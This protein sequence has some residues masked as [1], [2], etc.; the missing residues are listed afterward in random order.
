M[1]DTEYPEGTA[2]FHD[3]RPG[4]VAVSLDEALAKA[5]EEKARRE[6]LACRQAA[7]LRAL[8]DM[9]EQN[10]D[11]TEFASL[12]SLHAFHVRSAA[13]MGAI[14]RAAARSG[15][16]V[17]KKITDELHNVLLSWGP[18]GALVLA[19]RSEVCERLVL[20]SRKVKK[21]V[22]DPAALAAVPD[23]EVTETVEDVKWVCRPLLDDSSRAVS[24]LDESGAVA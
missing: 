10:P 7:G 6:E 19:W 11:L 24:S 20:G 14:V 17:E 18:V 1:S 3:A 23:V 16:K 12:A 9:I 4:E 21:T 8:A 13:D 5:A 15:A 2:E 22:K